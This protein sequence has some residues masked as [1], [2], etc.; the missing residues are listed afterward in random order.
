MP[1]VVGKYGEGKYGKGKISQEFP[2]FLFFFFF[3]L[4]FFN[5]LFS[6]DDL[7]LFLVRDET[8][9]TDSVSSVAPLAERE[10]KGTW[11]KMEEK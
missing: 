7:T 5:L 3:F 4:P 10:Q 2:R 9:D 11:K 6:F 8:S 1:K